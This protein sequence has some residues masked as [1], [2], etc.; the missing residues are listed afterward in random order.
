MSQSEIGK[1]SCDL[2]S[3]KEAVCVHTDK[4]T[5]SCLAKDCIEDL[6]VYLTLASQQVLDAASSARARCVE[7][8]HVSI[9]VESV[10]YTSGYYS[11]ELTYYYRV[12]AEASNT[13]ARPVI[14]T[15]LAVFSKKVVLFGGE[16]TARTYYSRECACSSRTQIENC[17]NPTAAV[18]VV[19]PI[20]L[21]TSVSDANACNCGEAPSIPDAILSCFDEDL[22]LQGEQ[23]RL[24]VTIGQF[25]ITR[26]QRST[27][28]LM[29]AFD[30]CIPTKDCANSGLSAS[31]SPCE[32]FGQIEFPIDSF[33]PTKNESC[34]PSEQSCTCCK[35]G[36]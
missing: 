17:G 16:S 10:P 24:L 8:I 31:G 11:A 1:S 35:A 9:N 2:R 23:K 13:N 32:V 6:R 30:Y 26:M 15:G 4:V 34:I 36:E 14:I 27:Q 29:P 12:T 3:V 25:S 19:D 5:D 7:L 20:V 21:G 28:L 22:V 18:E 33:F